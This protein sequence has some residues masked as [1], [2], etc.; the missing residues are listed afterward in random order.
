MLP[1]PY[2]EMEMSPETLFNH[3][4]MTQSPNSPELVWAAVENKV[5]TF[6]FTECFRVPLTVQG[7]FETGGEELLQC[8]GWSLC[9][10]GS[11]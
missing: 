1:R 3:V 6:F 11:R 5:Y 2:S 9:T 10:C 7:S 4:L 8:C